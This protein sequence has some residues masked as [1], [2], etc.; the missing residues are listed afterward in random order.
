MAGRRSRQEKC[1]VRTGVDRRVDIILNAGDAAG[2]SPERGSAE[3]PVQRPS[4]FPVTQILEASAAFEIG[5]NLFGE[6]ARLRAVKKPVRADCFLEEES[7][8]ADPNDPRAA[9]SFGLP[10]TDRIP[11]YRFF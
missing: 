6:T 4:G 1:T 3:G 10:D 11:V 5:C 7:G 2:E 9:E 8:S